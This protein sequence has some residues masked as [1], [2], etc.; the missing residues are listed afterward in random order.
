MCDAI[1]LYF[2]QKIDAIYFTGDVADHFMWD[3]TVES[4]KGEIA[5]AFNQMKLVFDGIPMY[6]ILGNHEAQNM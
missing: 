6:P 2:W 4:M 5:M 1:Q 3:A